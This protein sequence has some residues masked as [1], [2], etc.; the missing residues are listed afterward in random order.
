MNNTFPALNQ[1]LLK[2]RDCIL[3]IEHYFLLHGDSYYPRFLLIASFTLKRKGAGKEDILR[4][5]FQAEQKTTPFEKNLMFILGYAALL[6]VPLFKTLT[7]L[8]PY[9]GVLLA[10]GI[11]WMVSEIMH[12]KKAVEYKHSLTVNFIMQKIDSTSILFFLGILLAVGALET[13]GYLKLLADGL[14]Q[15]IGNIYSVNTLI[16]LLSAVVDNV[17]LVAA[18]MGMYDLSYYPTD[19]DFW[20]LLAYCA[21]TGGSI[22]IIGSAAGVASMGILKMDFLWYLRKISLYALVGYVAGIVVYYLQHEFG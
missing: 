22:L 14:N 10:L 13:S 12:R 7:Q 2:T 5:E 8:P 16:G 20:E 4:D 19:H 9:M 6:S 17:P 15:N 1:S 21:G 18:S 3:A 11:L